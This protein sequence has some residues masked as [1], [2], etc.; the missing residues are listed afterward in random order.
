MFSDHSLSGL[1]GVSLSSLTGFM[2]IG[3]KVIGLGFS[4]SI[5][6]NA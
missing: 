5:F 2:I 1:D 3:I 6:H 4:V